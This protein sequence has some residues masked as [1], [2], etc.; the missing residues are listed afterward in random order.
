M[1]KFTEKISLTLFAYWLKRVRDQKNS[2]RA[3]TL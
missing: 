3:Q 2:E 1:E